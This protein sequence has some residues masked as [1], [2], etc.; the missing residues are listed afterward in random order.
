MNATTWR[1]LAA[2]MSSVS[3]RA[4]SAAWMQDLEYHLWAALCGG[5]RQY[6]RLHLTDAQI[7]AMRAYSDAL[8][9]WVWFNDEA[10]REEFVPA[11]AWALRYEAW[12]RRVG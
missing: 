10:D 7:D 8:G 2:M 1:E 4:W 11:Q 5:P 12:Q 6:G 9:G 3:E